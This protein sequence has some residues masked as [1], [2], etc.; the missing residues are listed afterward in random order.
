VF[1]LQTLECPPDFSQA[2]ARSLQLQE[3]KYWIIDENIYWKHPLEIFLNC[4]VEE[5]IEGIIDVFQKGICRGH[6]C[7][8]A[9]SCKILRVGY[10]WPKLF[11]EVNAKVRS[12]R[13]CHFFAAKQNLLPCH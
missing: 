11:S 3:I 6:H 13:E 5:E 4:I 12:Y 7:W 9:T 10:Y 2:K 8:R 1:Y